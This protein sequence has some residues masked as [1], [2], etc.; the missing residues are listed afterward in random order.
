MV[1]RPGS[2]SAIGAEAV[3]SA[4]S[5]RRGASYHGALNPTCTGF[6]AD[7]SHAWKGVQVGSAAP[8]GLCRCAQKLASLPR[9]T[10]GTTF[11]TMAVGGGTAGV[12]ALRARVSPG[13]C[14]YDDV[15]GP[16]AAR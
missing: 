6:G 13:Q 15:A 9:P 12:V 16:R 1:R 4:Q 8:D 14:A 10:R 11:A 5:R 7:A 3:V 2:S